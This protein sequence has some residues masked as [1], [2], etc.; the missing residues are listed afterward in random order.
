MAHCN[1]TPFLRRLPFPKSVQEL[2]GLSRIM[3]FVSIQLEDLGLRKGCICEN[4]I[5][6]QGIK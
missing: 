1:H 4:M 3:D 6:Q 2:L 5:Y